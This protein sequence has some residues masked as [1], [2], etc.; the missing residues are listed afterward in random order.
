[1]GLFEL[2]V[3]GFMFGAFL[4]FN[5]VSQ[6]AARRRREQQRQE[7]EA[8]EAQRGYAQ[9][10]GVPIAD[11]L[12]QAWGR[13]P[14]AVPYEVAP[15][16]VVAPALREEVLAQ[17]RRVAAA[18]PRPVF[19]PPARVGRRRTKRHFLRTRQ[20]LRDAVVAMTV[21]GPCRALQPYDPGGASSA[22]GAEQAPARQS[23][24]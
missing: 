12:G 14:E 10:A 20:D 2:L 24:A 23:G 11:P 9:E 3:Y 16:E 4:L 8:V 22:G 18:A 6:Q 1:M 19:E 7:Q 5:Y 15:Y 21:L 17:A 13:A